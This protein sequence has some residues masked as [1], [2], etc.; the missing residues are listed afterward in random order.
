MIPPEQVL[1]TCEQ[2]PAIPT[3][4][5]ADARDDVSLFEQLE[6]DFDAGD[7]LA[8]D[9]WDGRKFTITRTR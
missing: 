5:I 6:T 7:T 9:L 2:R 3:K 4:A 8:F 1:E